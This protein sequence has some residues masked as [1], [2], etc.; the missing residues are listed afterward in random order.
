MSGINPSRKSYRQDT[1]SAKTRGLISEQFRSD[2]RGR[3]PTVGIM[4]QAMFGASGFGLL[5]GQGCCLLLQTCETDRFRWPH[6]EPYTW[7][8]RAEIFCCRVGLVKSLFCVFC[9][10]LVKLD[11]IGQFI[12][13]RSLCS[14]GPNAFEGEGE[15]GPKKLG[16]PPLFQH[17]LRE[18]LSK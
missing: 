12:W 5:T 6:S 2:S 14:R 4:S 9:F 11:K 17:K 8:W 13:A 16:H 3:D 7:H 10:H 18:E 15:R 1:S